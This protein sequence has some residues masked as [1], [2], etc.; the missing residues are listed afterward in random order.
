MTRG[1]PAS[2][3]STWARAK[4]A[5]FP[6]GDVKRV[7]KD[8][9]RAMLDAGKWSPENEAFVVYVRDCIVAAALEKGKSVVVDDTN[10][11]PE[12]EVRLREIAEKNG[13]VFE[14]VDF[15]HVSLEECIERDRPR[16]AS[17]GERVIREMWEQFLKPAASEPLETGESSPQR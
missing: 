11:A 3:K 8:D 17:V 14:V 16:S 15:T 6:Q 1:L 5:E 2:G 4:Q 10:L 7:N 12:H 13:V 9:L